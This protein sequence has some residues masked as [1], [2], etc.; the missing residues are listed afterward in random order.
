[1]YQRSPPTVHIWLLREG[2]FV[3][4]EL[5]LQ[6]CPADTIETIFLHTC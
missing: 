4:K 5:R 1:M 6:T 2:H 3:A